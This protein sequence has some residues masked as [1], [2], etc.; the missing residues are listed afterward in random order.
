MFQ[1]TLH[2]N[3]TYNLFKGSLLY[4]EC[5]SAAVIYIFWP[6]PLELLRDKVTQDRRTVNA[7]AVAQDRDRVLGEPLGVL[8]R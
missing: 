3:H 8:S 2:A 5:T 6:N 4:P 1:A 7:S